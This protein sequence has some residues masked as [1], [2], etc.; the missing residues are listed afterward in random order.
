MNITSCP[1]SCNVEADKSPQLKAILNLAVWPQNN[2]LRLVY[3][4]FLEQ[5]L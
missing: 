4:E 2:V 5:R 3:Q 1:C